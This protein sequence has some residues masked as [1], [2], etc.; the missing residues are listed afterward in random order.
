MYNLTSTDVFILDKYYFNILSLS[1]QI[2]QTRLTT[3]IIFCCQ[4]PEFQRHP[5]RPIVS[6]TNVQG[7][8]FAMHIYCDKNW[9]KKQVYTENKLYIGLDAT[10]L[11]P[12]NINTC[13]HIWF[14]IQSFRP[15]VVTT[16]SLMNSYTQIRMIG[17]AT[18]SRRKN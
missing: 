18:F 3:L 16:L 6:I 17:P 14:V 2:A 5:V 8:G 15:E 12:Q 4:S 11:A 10:I 1:A 9:T 13:E 7:F